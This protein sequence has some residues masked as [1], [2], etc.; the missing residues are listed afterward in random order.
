MKKYC[1]VIELKHEHIEDYINIH[2][3]AWPE[4]LKTIKE[5]G[6]KEEIIYNFKDMSIIFFECEDIDSIYKKLGETDVVKRWDAAVQPWF[7][8]EFIFPEKIF[9]LNQ[10]LKEQFVEQY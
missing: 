2:K 1:A 4:L 7:A 6:M 5:A 3:N 8:S 9:D 10:Q